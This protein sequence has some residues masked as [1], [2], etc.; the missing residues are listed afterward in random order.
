MLRLIFEFNISQIKIYFITIKIKNSLLLLALSFFSLT[1]PTQAQVSSGFTEQMN[2]KNLPP[3]E[4]QIPP[5]FETTHEDLSQITS[6]QV[7]IAIFVD[8]SGHITKTKIL[9]SSGS[10]GTDQKILLALKASKFFPYIENGIAMPF[11]GVQ[12]FKLSNKASTPIETCPYRFA[13]N[14]WLNQL[15]GI[16]TKSFIYLNRPNLVLQHK[17]LQSKD[18]T[19]SFQFKISD[20][21]RMTDIKITQSSG[22]SRLDHIILKALDSDQVQVTSKIAQ[23][24]N[25]IFEDSIDFKFSTCTTTSK[26]LRAIF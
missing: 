7:D 8:T 15:S 12:P 6:M 3:V 16:P 4:W 23:Q 20:K 21:Q 24:P 25:Q 19:I 11:I 2:I 5:N 14:T 9:K 10:T 26:L 22:L 18:R 17:E 1:T 13:S